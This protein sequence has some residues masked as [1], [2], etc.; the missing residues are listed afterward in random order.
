MNKP[1]IALLAALAAP[2]P[3]AAAPILLQL[4]PTNMLAQTHSRALMLSATGTFRQLSGTMRYDAATGACA[5]DVTFVVQS[6]TLPSAMMRERTM[7]A[8]FLDP[9]QY[10]LEHYFATCQGTSLTGNLTMRG[11]THPFTMTITLQRQG[12][13]LT[14]IHAT[15]TLNRY[16]WGIDGLKLLV[17]KTIRV[18]N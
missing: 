1:W 2:L 6:L 13:T 5:V 7:S 14:G 9:A 18:T 4:S 11:Q 8:G 16:D 17:G 10:P 12:A 3:A 15:G